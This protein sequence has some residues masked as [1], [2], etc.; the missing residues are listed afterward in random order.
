MWA[1][2]YWSETDFTGWANWATKD[3]VPS[4]SPSEAPTP[5]PTPTAI[6]TA[7][8]TPTDTPTPLIVALNPT[9]SPKDRGVPLNQL[10]LINYGILIIAVIIAI[11]LAVYKLRKTRAA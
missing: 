1:Y 3:S 7:A 6:S 4:P 9:P 10:Q 8:P 2:D 5:S 11:V